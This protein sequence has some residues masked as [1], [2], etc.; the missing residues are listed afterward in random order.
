[1]TYLLGSMG[2]A[3]LAVVRATAKAYHRFTRRSYY[4]GMRDDSVLAF[5]M[6]GIESY[7]LA[8]FP[9]RVLRRSFVPRAYWPE[10][11]AA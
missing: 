4:K 10:T 3:R 6:R 1:M 8:L 11:L 5:M 9:E 7:S 2:A